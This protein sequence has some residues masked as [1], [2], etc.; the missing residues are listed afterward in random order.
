MFVT[1]SRFA[2]KLWLAVS[3]DCEAWRLK[4]S[5]WQKTKYASL[6]VA[7]EATKIEPSVWR[8]KS[9]GP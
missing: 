2:N 4:E 9:S 8:T 5:I 7:L 3:F 1:I 6:T